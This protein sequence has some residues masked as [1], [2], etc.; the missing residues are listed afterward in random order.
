[1]DLLEPF[2]NKTAAGKIFQ[3]HLYCDNYF[4][5]LDLIVHSRK[6][7]LKCT[8]T[9]RDNRVKEKNVIDKRT[10]RGEYVVKHEKNSGM[11]YIT[12]VDS[13]PVSIVSTASGVTPL[14][15]WK[16]YKHDPKL[17]Y[18]SRKLS[19]CAT[20]LWEESIS[21]MDTAIMCFQAFVRKNGLRSFL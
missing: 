17:K 1:M 5:N 20:R 6:L 8:G 12:V 3:F 15:P 18:L 11:N 7:G 4:T 16:R 14:L 9:I 13:K 21:M 19:I 10:P 2:F